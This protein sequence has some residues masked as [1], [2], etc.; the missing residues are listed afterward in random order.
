MNPKELQEGDYIEIFFPEK[1]QSQLAEVMTLDKENLK[2]EF[3]PQNER[4]RIVISNPEQWKDVLPHSIFCQDLCALGFN[5]ASI[6]Y[7]Y[8][9]TSREWIRVSYNKKYVFHL[10]YDDTSWRLEVLWTTG[11]MQRTQIEE[12]I[13]YLHELQHQI[14]RYND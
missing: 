1:R 3:Q 2:A 14:K 12:G 9:W 8:G 13:H 4:N 11:M 10:Y 5:E 6:D 7:A